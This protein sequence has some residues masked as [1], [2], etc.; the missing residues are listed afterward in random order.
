VRRKRSF[1][2]DTQ[3]EVCQNERSLVGAGRRNLPVVYIQ[4]RY[5]AVVVIDERHPAG[6]VDAVH[7]WSARFPGA[8]VVAR[9]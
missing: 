6:V 5:C 7:T 9:K 2:K 8:F 3:P 4:V 1:V